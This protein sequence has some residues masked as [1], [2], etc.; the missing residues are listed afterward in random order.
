MF[1]RVRIH[2]S[3]D[4]RRAGEE[5]ER[6]P[7]SSNSLLSSVAIAKSTVPC[8][9]SNRALDPDKPKSKVISLLGDLVVEEVSM[10][11]LKSKAMTWHYGKTKKVLHTFLHG[12]F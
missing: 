12:F 8:A 11:S 4:A 1:L 10:Q 3:N 6:A 5:T 2:A 7:F 9:T